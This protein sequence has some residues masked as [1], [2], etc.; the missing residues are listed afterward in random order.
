[1]IEIVGA[2]ATKNPM[3]PVAEDAL[4]SPKEI[5][6]LIGN[7]FTASCNPAWGG[8]PL[9][10]AR[11]GYARDYALALV[12]KLDEVDVQTGHF[13]NYTEIVAMLL[14]AALAMQKLHGGK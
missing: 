9:S 7:A 10:E 14:G 8:T 12:T 4:F 5:G 1:M 3:V 11:L 2:M 6:D 13:K